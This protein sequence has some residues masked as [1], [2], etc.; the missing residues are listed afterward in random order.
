[1][2]QEKIVRDSARGLVAPRPTG[3]PIPLQ[4]ATTQRVG[5]SGLGNYL[6]ELVTPDHWIWMPGA[7]RSWLNQINEQ[8]R[9]MGNDISENHSQIV[10]ASGGPRFITDFQ[11]LRSRWLLFNRTASTWYSNIIARAQEFVNAYNALENRYRGVAGSAP[12]VYAE[13]SA[14]EAP[15]ALRTANN[16]LMIWSVIGIVGVV[17]AGYLLSNYAKIKTLSKLT[18]N[19]RKRR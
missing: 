9:S 18:L 5:L 12:T 14:D 10:A 16:N 6:G 13:L 8:I 17:G 1:M 2:T 15:S 7:V 19:S 4:P 3:V 11:E